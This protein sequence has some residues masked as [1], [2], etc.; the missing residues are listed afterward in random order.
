MI[1]VSVM[2]PN[3]D[4]VVFD[5]EYYLNTHVPLVSKLLGN[6]LKNAQVDFGISS[7]VPG[8]APLYVV[9]TNM[10]FESIETFQA[11]FAPN[12]EEI[13]SDIANF[14]NCQPQLQISEVQI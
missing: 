7:A 2:Y 4:D 14:T 6:S 1:K 8:E 12:S 13:L 11:I 3:S 5:K 9:I 10:T